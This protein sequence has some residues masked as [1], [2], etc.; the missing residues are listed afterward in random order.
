[1]ATGSSHRSG[2]VRRLVDHP[3]RWPDDGF[4]LNEFLIVVAVIGLLA[5]I[6][7]PVL[8]Q[9]R[10]AASDASAKSDLKST[11][12]AIVMYINEN[13]TFPT[14]EVDLA[15]VDFNLSGG[16]SFSKFDVKTKKGIASAH[17]HI[18]HIGSSNAWHADLPAEGSVIQFR[19]R[20]LGE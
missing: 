2:R 7:V 5:G 12:R 13:G 9:A 11:M 4:T 19:K 18:E 8:A 17:I 3:H 15:T 14:S 10:A 6:A 20:K 16:V 1:L